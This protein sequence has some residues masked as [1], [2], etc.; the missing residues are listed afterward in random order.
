MV[1]QNI[2]VKNVLLDQRFKPLL[3]DSGL[4]QLLTKDTVFS[5]LKASAAMGSL[6]PEYGT[7]GRFTQKSDIYPFGVLVFQI[8]SGKRKF[9]SAARFAAESCTFIDFIDSNLHGRF[10]EHE[11]AKFAKI[12]LMCTHE[13]PDQRPSVEEVVQELA[14][15]TRPTVMDFAVAFTTTMSLALFPVEMNSATSSQLPSY[16]AIA[17]LPDIV[18]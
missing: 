18:R 14:A 13:S 8:I 1:H 15:A 11:A 10:R 9:A 6:A 2:S 16:P 7:T 3:S 5:S 4:H 17:S 12:A